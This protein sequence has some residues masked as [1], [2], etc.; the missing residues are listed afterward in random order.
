MQ[1]GQ[2]LKS[3]GK[4]YQ[5][6]YVEGISFDS[7]KVKKKDIFFAITGN[8]TSGLSRRQSWWRTHLAR[9]SGCLMSNPRYH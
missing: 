7:R 4:K 5:K 8:Q 6:I 3:V 2:L 1:L 9:S